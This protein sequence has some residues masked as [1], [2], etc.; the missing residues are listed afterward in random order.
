MKRFRKQFCWE[1][2][3]VRKECLQMALDFKDQEGVWGGLLPYEGR[4]RNA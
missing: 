3:T 2:C 1:T 4:R